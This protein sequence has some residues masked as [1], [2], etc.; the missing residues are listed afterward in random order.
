MQPVALEGRCFVLTA[1]HHQ[2]A[3]QGPGRTLFRLPDVFQLTINETPMRP[4]VHESTT[5]ST[6]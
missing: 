1:C 6:G 3:R 5:K 2:P 4:V